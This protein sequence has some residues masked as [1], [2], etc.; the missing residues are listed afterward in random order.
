MGP[1][2]LN[3]YRSNEN[4]FERNSFT[5]NRCT[6]EYSSLKSL[7]RHVFHCGKIL[8][9]AL[10]AS[11][12][13][14]VDEN[15]D[16]RQFV[17]TFCSKAY[18]W[19]KGLKVHQER[20]TEKLAQE[21]FQESGDPLTLGEST[22]PPVE[23]NPS[24][25]GILQEHMPPIILKNNSSERYQCSLCGKSYDWMKNLR[26]HQKLCRK[27]VMSTRW[28]NCKV[29]LETITSESSGSN[30]CQN[31]KCV[32]CGKE[33]RWLSS[34]KEH[35]AICQEKQLLNNRN[36]WGISDVVSYKSDQEEEV[37]IISD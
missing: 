10:G 11:G 36:E 33:F 2:S 27:K 20:C 22:D 23:N 37:D 30:T 4:Q 28:K 34:L 5:C 35:D 7:R 32:H 18:R 24:T 14:Y 16:E 26:R 3:E 29:M 25:S 8:S 15:G 6:R 21:N 31:F 19:K 1:T 13:H 9:Q 17:C 12:V